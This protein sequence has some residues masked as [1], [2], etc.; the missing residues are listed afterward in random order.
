MGFGALVNHS[1]SDNK[2]KE[3]KSVNYSMQS[4]KSPLIN[5]DNGRKND[6]SGLFTFLYSK[7]IDSSR[8]EAQESLK[9]ILNTQEE[10][11]NKKLPN[12]GG[13]LLKNWRNKVFE[14]LFENK[15]AELLFNQK[16]KSFEQDK[17]KLVD[18]LDNSN[19]LL[20]RSRQDMDACRQEL[21]KKE[22]ELN[23]ITGSL[24]DEEFD[25]LKAYLKEIILKHSQTME[26]EEQKLSDSMFSLQSF[27]KRLQIIQKRMKTFYQL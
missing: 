6:D 1:R 12:V 11:I 18:E 8:L 3:A 27:H 24:K 16:F 22:K 26:I 15:K 5:L 14:L 20:A 17:A 2:S 13:E 23:Q 9:T 21:K 25:M 7:G 4:Q 19:Y 10:F